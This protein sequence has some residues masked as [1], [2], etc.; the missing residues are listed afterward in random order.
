MKFSFRC[1]FCFH[2]LSLFFFF[3]SWSIASPKAGVRHAKNVIKRSLLIGMKKENL[4]EFPLLAENSH[5]SEVQNHVN[6]SREWFCFQFL[7]LLFKKKLNSY[8]DLFINFLILI[9]NMFDWIFEFIFLKSID[10]YWIWGLNKMFIN[11]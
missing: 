5:L 8:F 6:S 9:R 7:F 10:L 1:V 3:F 2:S 4:K 11:V